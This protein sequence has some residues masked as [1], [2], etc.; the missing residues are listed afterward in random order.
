MHRHPCSNDPR[1]LGN[2]VRRRSQRSRRNP[3]TGGKRAENDVRPQRGAVLHPV[4]CL[5]IRS[6]KNYGDSKATAIDAINDKVRTVAANCPQTTFIFA[7]YSQGA[8]ATGDIASGIGNGK[9]PISADKVL[10][11][12]LLADPGRGTVGESTSAHPQPEPGLQTPPPRNGH[13][14]R[15]G[16]DDL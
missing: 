4:R 16:R 10:A 1:Y 11:V 15:T 3:R 13:A 6:G 14:Q 12:G 9:C 7:G 5:G 8:D 2:H